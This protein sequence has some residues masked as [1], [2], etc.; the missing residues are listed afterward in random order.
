MAHLQSYRDGWR[1]QLIAATILYKFAFVSQPIY[2]ADDVGV[3]FFCTLFK[4]EKKGK[5]SELIPLNSIV[6]QIKSE[7]KDRQLDLSKHISYLEQLELPY[8]LGIFCEKEQ[9]L[10]IYSGEFLT[11]LFAF[12]GIPQ[13]LIINMCEELPTDYGNWCNEIADKSYEIPFPKLCDLSASMNTNEFEKGT[14]KLRQHSW[15]YQKNIVAYR[16]NTFVFIE[17]IFEKVLL[18]MRT[19]LEDKMLDNWCKQLISQFFYIQKKRENGQVMADIFN[20]F[21]ATYIQLKD[22]LISSRYYGALCERYTAAKTQ[23][24][25]A[26]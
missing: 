11:Y 21:E 20:S 15:T 23:K 7:N 19:G 6:I 24:K 12:K 2:S 14:E 18:F 9:K 22:S 8:F 10:S 17:P 4:P 1:H 16:E 26:N 5:N 25:N 3:D 13:K